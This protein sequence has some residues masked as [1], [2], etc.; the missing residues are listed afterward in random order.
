MTDSDSAAAGTPFLQ[1]QFMGTTLLRMIL[2]VLAMIP[3]VVFGHVFGKPEDASFL[4]G[5]TVAY[6]LYRQ[7]E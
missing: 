5:F 6:I 4:C 3:F 1:R 2:S 7:F